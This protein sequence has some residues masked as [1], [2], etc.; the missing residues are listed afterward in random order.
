MVGR[1]DALAALE[2]ALE[3]A[4]EGSPR[5][6]LVAGDAGV[7]KT[8][9]A[10]ELAGRADTAGREVLWGECVPVQAGELPYAPIVAALRGLGSRGP[11]MASSR[12]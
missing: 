3:R 8:R 1:E 7:G 11:V 5:L 4:A 2:A 9:L 10:R 12:A 6:V